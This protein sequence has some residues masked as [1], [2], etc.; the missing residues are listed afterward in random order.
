VDTGI[1]DAPARNQGHLQIALDPIDDA[2]FL[3]LM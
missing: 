1:A 3:A 2:A